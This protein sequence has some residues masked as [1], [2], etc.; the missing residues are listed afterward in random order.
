[1]PLTWALVLEISIILAELINIIVSCLYTYFHWWQCD[2]ISAVLS[3]Q[4][5]KE[6][7][8][9]VTIHVDSATSTCMFFIYV[10]SLHL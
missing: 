7:N 4:R 10:Y 5:V 6:F 1:M 8:E 9:L 2:G 3:Q